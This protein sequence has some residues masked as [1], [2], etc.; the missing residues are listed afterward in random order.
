MIM[1]NLDFHDNASH[2]DYLINTKE[3][4]KTVKKSLEFIRKNKLQDTF[5]AI[6]F[7]GLSGAL[8]APILASRLDKTLIA[9][10]KHKTCEKCGNSTAHSYRTVEGNLGANRYIIVDD[11]VSSGVTVRTIIKSIAEKRKTIL[12]DENLS[13]DYKNQIGKLEY[14]GVLCVSRIME[15]NY[16]KESQFIKAGN[17]WWEV[18][19]ES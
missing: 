11:F 10:R 15:K 9:V 13:N 18:K 1:K 19:Y 6:A 4:K 8:I 3:L 7:R 17:G 2:L 5:D 14:I 12:E 16:N